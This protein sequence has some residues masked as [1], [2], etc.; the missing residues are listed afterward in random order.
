M[1]AAEIFWKHEKVRDREIENLSDYKEKY[2]SFIDISQIYTVLGG[3]GM[4]LRRK[5]VTIDL[6]DDLTGGIAIIAW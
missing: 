6:I 5:L 4:L 1:P 2:G 3:L